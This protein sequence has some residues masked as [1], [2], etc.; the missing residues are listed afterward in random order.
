MDLQVR[1]DKRGGKNRPNVMVTAQMSNGLSLHWNNEDLVWIR[2]EG[3]Y[4]TEDIRIL[5][6]QG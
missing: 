5:E 3:L 1:K 4:N 2:D 6:S